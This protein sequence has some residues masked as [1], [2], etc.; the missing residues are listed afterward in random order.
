MYKQIVKKC[1]GCNGEFMGF[2]H[3]KFCT[4]SCANK[5]KEM[6][7]FHGSSTSFKKGMIPW[8]RGLKGEK[9]HMFGKHLKPASFSLERRKAISERMMGHKLNLGK[10]V[11]IETKEKM[12]LAHRGELSHLWRGGLTK[13]VAQIRKNYIYR[14]WRSDVFTRDDFTCQECGKRGGRLNADH[15]EPFAIVLRKNDI[16]SLDEAFNCNELWNINNGRTLCVDCHKNTDTYLNRWAVELILK[17]SVSPTMGGGGVGA[18]PTEA[19]AG[20]TK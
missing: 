10:K 9:S 11:S 16:T 18:S 1:E 7:N 5:Y 13:L 17:S 3:R 12:S 6:K 14:Q 4:K 20:I 15:I 8:N 2:P 19:L